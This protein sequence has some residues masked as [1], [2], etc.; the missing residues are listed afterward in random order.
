MLGEKKIIRGINSLGR[1][2]GNSVAKIG[3]K[4][5]DVLNK[6]DNGINRA[7]NIASNAINKVA[8]AG[9]KVINKS[10]QV[11]DA[12]R[13]GSKIANAVASNLDTLGV[14]G[15]SLA[16]AATRQLANGASMLDA[17]R[18]NIAHKI[19]NAR[20]TA[21]I[22]KQNLRKKVDEQNNNLKSQV[23]NFV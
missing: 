16:H 21:Q 13:V 6:I 10:G 19:E 11:T 12:L 18:D 14:P 4:T 22:E 5:H 2:A 23:S 9:Q 7:D 3:Q 20:Q 1:K 17:K 15:G 8:G